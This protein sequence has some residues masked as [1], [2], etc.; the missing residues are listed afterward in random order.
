M[1]AVAAK[2]Q[3]TAPRISD[4]V[5]D[6]KIEATWDPS[7]NQTKQIRRAIGVSAR[8]RRVKR[9]ET[10]ERKHIL[11]SGTFGIV[12]LEECIA[13]SEPNHDSSR[14]RAVK[15]IR[16][17]HN[18][19]ASSFHRELEAMA[20]FSQERFE[21]YFVHSFGWFEDETKL[22]ITM[23]YLKHGGSA[24]ISHEAIP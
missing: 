6:S 23:E 10:W 21:H 17:P 18:V 22:F 24:A 3:A 4:L 19:S 8:N 7:T 2:P 1:M 11:G 20:K 14:L 13:S 16:K 12:W 9:D 15:E 5:I